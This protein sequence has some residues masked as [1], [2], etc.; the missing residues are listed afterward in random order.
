MCDN[1]LFLLILSFVHVLILTFSD[2]EFM[3][4][5]QDAACNK[6]TPHIQLLLQKATLMFFSKFKDRLIWAFY[7]VKFRTKLLIYGINQ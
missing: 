1:A 7:H 5:Q 2:T 4:R 3:S 6:A